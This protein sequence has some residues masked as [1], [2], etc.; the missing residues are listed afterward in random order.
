MA[1][2]LAAAILGSANQIGIQPVD[3]ATVISFETGGTFDPWQRGPTTKWGQH[4]GLIQMGEPQ[5][6]QYGYQQGAPLSEQM[7][8]VE[9]YLVAAGVKPG[10]GLLDIESAINAGG[11]GKYNA[12]DMGTTVSQKVAGMGGHR[13]NAARLLGGAGGGGAAGRS[14]PA[15]M[16]AP[17]I[18][19]Q[20]ETPTTGAVRVGTPDPLS[21][22][23]DMF[24]PQLL[25][26][27]Q[28]VDTQAAEQKRRAALFGD[29]GRLY[30]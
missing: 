11:V 22:L 21:P 12:R 16:Q 24:A 9:K 7:R 17:L 27:Q 29:L 8:A 30:G 14:T 1:S 15:Q 6:A 2:D 13:R 10:M 26:Q 5:R 4:R 23:A 25:Q 18:V 3:L 19:P 28:E 20:A